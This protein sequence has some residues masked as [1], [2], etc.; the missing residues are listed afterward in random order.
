MNNRRRRTRVPFHT[1][2]KFIIQG[3]ALVSSDS[4]DLSLTGFIF[5]T[6]LRPEEGATGEVELTLGLG[7]HPLTLRFKGVVARADENGIGVRFLEMDPAAFAHL[8]NLL[9]YNT[10]NPEAIDAEII[11]Y[12]FD[13]ESDSQSIKNSSPP[14]LRKGRGPEE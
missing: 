3:I 5:L 7:I 12:P 9:Y 4:K 6:D 10:G 8:K 2:V 1:R 11:H 14:P 13:P